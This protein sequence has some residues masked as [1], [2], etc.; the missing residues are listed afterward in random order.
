MLPSPIRLV[1]GADVYRNYGVFLDDELKAYPI[2][3]I[4]RYAVKTIEFSRQFVEPQRSM[5]RIYLDKP[6][7]FLVLAEKIGMSRDKPLRPADV[8]LSVEN[9]RHA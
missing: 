2:G 4:D 8:A 1:V 6:E 9:P 3:H 7:C 5:H